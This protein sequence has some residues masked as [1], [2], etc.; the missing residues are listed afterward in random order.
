MFLSLIA[1]ERIQRELDGASQ[2]EKIFCIYFLHFVYFFEYVFCIF[3]H[4]VSVLLQLK[5]I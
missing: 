1:E 2:N 4:F 3:L 5:T